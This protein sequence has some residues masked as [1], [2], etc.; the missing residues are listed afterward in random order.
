MTLFDWLFFSGAVTAA[1]GCVLP[2]YNRVWL[3]GLLLLI[4]AAVVAVV[5]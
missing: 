3:A 2:G 5:H 1:V 4:F